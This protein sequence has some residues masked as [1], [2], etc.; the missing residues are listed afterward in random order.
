[1]HIITWNLPLIYMILQILPHPGFNSHSPCIGNSNNNIFGHGTGNKTREIVKRGYCSFSFILILRYYPIQK[2]QTEV[3][4]SY[5]EMFSFWEAVHAVRR[6]DILTKRLYGNCLWNLFLIVTPG[7]RDYIGSS[8]ISRRKQENWELQDKL[9]STW[10]ELQFW[11]LCG[12]VGRSPASVQMNKDTTVRE[13][14]GRGRYLD[15]KLYRLANVTKISNYPITR[16]AC[17]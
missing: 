1:M 12:G 15:G 2:A 16:K 5:T 8:Y 10:L 11:K 9:P 3:T 14:Y 6:L 17:C 13:M 4:T 7:A